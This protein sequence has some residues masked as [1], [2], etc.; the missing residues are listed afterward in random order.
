MKK[1]ILIAIAFISLQAAA[2][3]PT[4]G[5]RAEMMENRMSFM[6][7][8]SVNQIADLQ[9]KRMIF[10]LNLTSIQKN[11]VRK[12][13]L[14]IANTRKEFAKTFKDR[15]TKGKPSAE[16]IYAMMNKR[17]DKQIEVKTA[18]KQILSKEQLEKWS[19]MQMKNSAFGRPNFM[20][21]K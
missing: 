5:D 8:L 2:Q 13:N 7:D 20:G 18:L 4:N 6:D 15:K 10:R 12:I 14:D 16:V 17:L 9:T 3:R 11:G 21:R 1:V 19:E